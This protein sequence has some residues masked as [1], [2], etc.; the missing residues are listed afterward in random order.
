MKKSIKM[1]LSGPKS[2]DVLVLLFGISAGPPHWAILHPP[3]AKQ[4]S[5]PLCVKI[6]SKLKKIPIK[7]QNS[8]PLPPATC[9]KSFFLESS[10]ETVSQAS[11]PLTHWL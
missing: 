10:Q 4:N 6:I 9:Y 8:H 1:C 2:K 7:V 3:L 5:H 11:D